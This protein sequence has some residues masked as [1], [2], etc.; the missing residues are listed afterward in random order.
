ME[1]RIITF[2]LA[3]LITSIG[4]LW[5]SVIIFAK[6]KA[7]V[8]RQFSL[9]Y[10]V[11]SVYAFGFFLQAIAKSPPQEMVA[12]KILLFGTILIPVFTFTAVYSL[13]NRPLSNSTKVAI[14]LSAIVLENINIFTNLFAR[15]PIPKFGL[16]C[17][18]QAGPLY[19]LLIVFFV[20]VYLSV[21][22]LYLYYRNTTGIERNRLKY[23]LLSFLVGFPGGSFGFLIGYNIDI[24]P[25]NPFTT[26]IILVGNF[27]VTYS[28][29]KYRLM[30]IKLASA[31]AG[32]F[33]LVYAFVLGIPILI[34]HSMLGAVHFWY[35]PFALGIL[36][37]FEGP[38]IY[39]SL[40]NKAESILLAEQRRYQKILIQAA[41]GMSKQHDLEKLI[42]LIVYLVKKTVKITFASIFLYNE[43][44]KTFDLRAFRDHGKIIH[45][46]VFKEDHPF[47]IF[48]KTKAEPFLTEEIPED[49]KIS[50]GAGYFQGLIIPSTFD[51]KCTGFMFLGEKINGRIYSTDD[52]NVFKILSQQSTLA[53][54]NCIFMEEFKRSQD[55]LFTAEKLASIGGMA[56]GIA[57]QMRNRLNQFSVIADEQQFEIEEFR[58]NSS[59]LINK[60]EK[61]KETLA[62]LLEGAESVTKNV[63]KT[64]TMI[65]GVLDFANVDDKSKLFSEISFK[66]VVETSVEAIKI[67][68][69]LTSFPLK[70]DYGKDDKVYG[71]EIQLRESL[72]NILDNAYEAIKE[73]IDYHLKE[74]EK[75]KFEPEILLKLIQKPESSVIEIKDNG[76]GIK[77]DF[78]FKIFS[79][80]FTTKPSV[81]SGTG[82]GMYVVKRMIEENHNG[83]IRFESQYGLGTTIIIE[84]P[85]NKPRG[86]QLT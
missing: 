40:R 50:L 61:L 13:I 18:F 41:E 75:I 51:K 77:D 52:I 56:E 39:N 30:D 66:E 80:F 47:I 7:N 1:F 11:V 58:K 29:I 84:L 79:P 45:A 35:L 21:L 3:G 8:N 74:E 63:K 33:L 67:K 19:P 54:Q 25:L 70:T 72:F 78:K 23:V 26:Y 15:D 69:Q 62:Y 28:I 59:D 81:K 36:L 37:A 85:K 5:L 9:F 17:V 43:K 73:K 86:T 53:I 4:N 31:R 20:L 14:F 2:A 49:V 22:Q 38:V 27:F 83:K 6:K 12:I 71:V 10:L 76:I 60:N 42:K 44:N 64:A 68:H 82:I 55:R 24:Y 57:H 46:K 65:Q 16:K 34:G 32:I 48:I